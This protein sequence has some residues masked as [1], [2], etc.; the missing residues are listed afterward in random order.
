MKLLIISKTLCL[1]MI[2]EK[3]LKI[4]KIREMP[5]VPALN[6]IL[7]NVVYFTLY[8]TLLPAFYGCLP[9]GHFHPQKRNC[10]IAKILDVALK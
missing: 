6:E 3:L 9:C 8:L 4:L 5:F 2:F 10:E 1:G 7:M